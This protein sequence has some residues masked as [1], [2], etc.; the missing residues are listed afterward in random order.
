MRQIQRKSKSSYISL[1]YFR[2]GICFISHMQNMD[3][4][5]VGSDSVRSP[6]VAQAHH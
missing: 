2:T 5:I 6:L 1:S 4:S 3:S